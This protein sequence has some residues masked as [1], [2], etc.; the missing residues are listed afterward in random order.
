VNGSCGD[1]TTEIIDV[2]PGNGRSLP[3]DGFPYSA[4]L[5]VA[6]PDNIPQDNGGGHIPY[7]DPAGMVYPQFSTTPL[8]IAAHVVVTHTR[9][10]PTFNLNE[11]DSDSNRQWALGSVDLSEKLVDSTSMNGTYTNCVTPF[12]P[13]PASGAAHGTT[14]I[15]TKINED[16][17]ATDV[18]GE[19]KVTTRGTFDADGNITVEGDV[20]GGD[21]HEHVDVTDVDDIHAGKRRLPP[22]DYKRNPHQ[23]GI[24]QRKGR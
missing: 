23:V 15:E 13:Y 6:T 3:H 16:G 11:S 20:T 12:N 8:P 21:I 14:T 19:E 17:N 18:Q 5:Y 24:R 9:S 4:L 7:G 1:T 10:A 2:Q 22:T